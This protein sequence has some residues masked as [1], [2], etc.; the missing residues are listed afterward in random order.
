M[1]E[2]SLDSTDSFDSVE[3]YLKQLKKGAPRN[4]LW[5]RSDTSLTL[6]IE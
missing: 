4:G 5:L 1:E 6:V 2:S 3:F